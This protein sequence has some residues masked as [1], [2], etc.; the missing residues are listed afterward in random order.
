MSEGFKTIFT[1]T[2]VTLLIWLYAEQ[3]NPPTPLEAK[4]T[5]QLR[6]PEGSDLIAR[7]ADPNRVYVF[8]FSGPRA[9][10][11]ELQR[12]IQL[13]S[14]R[15]TL[16]VGDEI[17]ATPGSRE[18]LAR[19]VLEKHPWFRNKGITISESQMQMLRV[20]IDRWVEQKLPVVAGDFG[21]L[22][23]EGAVL[24][25]PETM[26]VEMAE[27]LLPLAPNQI[28]LVATPARED[29][30]Q[31]AEG[32]SHTI[33]V[34]VQLVTMLGTNANQVRLPEGARA[35]LTFRLKSRQAQTT[36][37]PVPIKLVILPLDQNYDVTLAD[38]VISEITLSGP[39]ELINRV[40]N[41]EIKIFGYLDL[42]S[43]ELSSGITSKAVSF[44]HLSGLTVIS[45][46]HIANFTITRRSE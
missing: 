2:V 30:D 39:T 40:K 29:L 45:G 11:D 18:Y 3:A 25:E 34:R 20:S 33:D 23:I 37:G 13:A 22:A 4:V 15:I 21:D 9:Q 41:K 27:S 38:P 19:S 24:V 31:L 10:L 26:T 35:S 28:R 6:T 17:D 7:L 32:Q 42:D 14:D 1:V 8:Q 46:P 12:N 44:D 16:N 5:F 36:F 43:V